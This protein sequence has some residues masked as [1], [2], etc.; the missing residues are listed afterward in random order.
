MP[1]GGFFEGVLGISEKKNILL[2]DFDGERACKEI[3]FMHWKKM[4]MT[5]YAEEEFYTVICREKKF[6][7]ALHCTTPKHVPHSLCRLKIELSL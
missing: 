3:T 4:L 5:Y 2:A 6:R 1:T 7:T